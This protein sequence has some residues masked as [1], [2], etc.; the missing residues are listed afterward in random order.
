M[1]VAAR[2]AQGQPQESHARRVDAI[3]YGLDTILLEVD[4]AFEVQQSIT[5]KTGRYDLLLG[6]IR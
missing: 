4:S 6:G 3:D 2:T 5:V 1:V